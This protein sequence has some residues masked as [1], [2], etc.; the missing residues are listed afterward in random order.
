MRAV[1]WCNGSIPS[2]EVLESAILPGDSLYGVDGGALNAVENGYQVVEAIGDLDSIDVNSWEGGLVRLANQSSSDL[3]KSISLLAKRG[4]EQIEVVGV[5]GGSPD[6]ILGNWAALLEAPEG[7]SIRLHHE[8]G[9]TQRLHPSEG[10]LETNMQ[11]G[12]TFSVFAL[13]PAMVWVEGAKWEI[14]GEQLSL[15]TRGLSNEGVGKCVSIKSTGILAV[16][17]RK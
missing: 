6:H 3:V 16:V 12:S 4:F 10:E 8:E 11:N 17:F 9:V 7:V 1:L 5:D 15:S 2:K 14:S 13:E